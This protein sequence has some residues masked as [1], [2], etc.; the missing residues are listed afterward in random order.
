MLTNEKPIPVL[1]LANKVCACYSIVHYNFSIYRAGLDFDWQLSRDIYGVLRL[2]L[3]VSI[4][5]HYLFYIKGDKLCF[6][7]IGF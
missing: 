6:T 1:L 7:I 2:I 4:P 3:G 5:F